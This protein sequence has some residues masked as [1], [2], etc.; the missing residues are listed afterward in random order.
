MTPRP[1]EL[2]LL[3]HAD[4]GDPESW[5]GPDEDRPLSAKGRRQASRLGSYL[6]ALGFRADVVLTSPKVRARETA[7]LAAAA[8]GLRVVED[9]RLGS[10]A[11]LDDVEEV[12]AAAGDPDS[13]VLVGHDPDFSEMVAE[14]TGA[15]IPVRKGAIVRLD[16]ER[17]LRG[18]TAVLRW[19][20]PP[21]A[22]PKE[23]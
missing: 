6:A 17:P 19:L 11:T 13:A 4:A 10:G 14:L 8:T 23:R 15:S 20:I 2:Y 16:A 18:G 7:E 3:R 9:G 12:L 5:R 1:V 21:D 22:I